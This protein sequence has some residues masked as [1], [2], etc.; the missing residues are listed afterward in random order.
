MKNSKLITF[1]KTLSSAEMKEWGKYIEA[2]YS[3]K[4]EDALALFDYLKKY[5][6]EF[7]D[8][9]IE[10]ERIARKIYKNDTNAI[11]KID[12]IMYKFWNFLEGYIIQKELE[13]SQKLQ[14]FLLLK[15]LKN[16]K[17]DKYF[18]KKVDELENDWKGNN[19]RGAD[20]IF[21]LY[22]LKKIRISHPNYVDRTSTSF[23]TKSLIKEIEQLYLAV[24]LRL[25][26]SDFMAHG[27]IKDTKEKS[28]ELLS[29]DY[30][31]EFVSEN[32]ETHNIHVNIYN[33]LH[34]AYSGKADSYERLTELKKDLFNHYDSFTYDEQHDIADNLSNLFFLKYRTGTLE[35]IN[36]L[37]ELN[38]FLVDNNVIN[39]EGYIVAH[40]FQNIVN[41]ACGAQQTEWAEQFIEEKQH[42]LE[43]NFKEDIVALSK[44]SVY[45]KTKEYEKVLD[46]LATIKF[47]NVFNSAFAR[48]IQLIAY[49][50]LDDY[51]ELFI[52]HHKS[53]SLF[54]LR[55]KTLSEEHKRSFSN[56]IH[57]TKRLFESKYT[58]NTDNQALR[59]EVIA[60][61]QI[62]YQ[63]WLLEKVT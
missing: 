26:L 18:F 52:N 5:H 38:K 54:L 58:R 8:K 17:L 30:L 61:K 25:S 48:A 29:L 1:L 59:A 16:R 50:E 13:D 40:T 35:A 3:K 62:V 57:F 22:K 34:N 23:N 41:V 12:N 53:F 31:N 63:S 32:N 43:E 19:Y 46:A 36:D 45:L 27:Y 21:D 51:E 24:K 60:C 11:K 28:F 49:F 20:H 15:A 37:F 56:F 47:K 9:F 14:D 2:N 7:E 44:S 33:G 42:F 39:H 6:P 4:A 10:K 55:N